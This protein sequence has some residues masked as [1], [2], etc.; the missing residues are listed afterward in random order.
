MRT[1]S[2]VNL[3]IFKTTEA[4]HVEAAEFI[5]RS[6]KK[7]VAEQGKFSVVLSGGN[8]PKK[9]YELLAEKQYSEQMPWKETFVFWG[10]ERCVGLEDAENN[11]YQAK[12]ILLNHVL[13]PPDNIYI[14]PVNLPSP[15]AARKYEQEIFAF[16]GEEKPCFD[17]ILL[18]LGENG[19]TASLFPHTKV[20]E[21]KQAGVQEVYIEEKRTYRITMTVPLIN[22]AKQVLFL[23]IGKGKAA[24]LKNIVADHSN[25][26]RYPAQLIHPQSGEL[27]WFV[28]E[29]A[30][31]L[32]N[33]TR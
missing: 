8:T 25:S 27:Y 4:L 6:A 14:I 12:I 21:N 1:S 20:L 17:L 5:I 3:K 24:I 9:L 2:T 16:F 31:T 32:L 26:T 18:G 19:H 23:V 28:D 29:A 10:D 33:E 22:S 15:L 13:I 7:A 30:A 11:A